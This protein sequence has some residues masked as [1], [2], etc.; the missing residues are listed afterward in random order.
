MPYLYASLD[1]Q[2]LMFYGEYKRLLKDEE[3]P[4]VYR[5]FR[6]D[7]SNNIDDHKVIVQ[8]K[9]GPV[10]NFIRN[11]SSGRLAPVELWP[12]VMV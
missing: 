4:V 9:I 12:S 1:I 7:N 2:L 3:Q 5:T 10:R 11:F 6:N 8:E